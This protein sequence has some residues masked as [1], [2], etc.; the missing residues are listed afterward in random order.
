[1]LGIAMLVITFSVVLAVN[2]IPMF[3]GGAASRLRNS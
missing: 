2:R 1:V 3:G